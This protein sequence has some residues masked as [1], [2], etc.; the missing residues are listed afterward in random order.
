MLSI[1]GNLG[2]FSACHNRLKS[3]MRIRYTP[4]VDKG[5]IESCFDDA[6]VHQLNIVGKITGFQNSIVVVVVVVSVLVCDSVSIVF[7]IH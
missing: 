1:F 4:S 2:A 5:K 6:S 7:G 3:L